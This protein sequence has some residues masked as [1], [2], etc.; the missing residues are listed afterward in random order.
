M[1]AVAESATVVLGEQE[2]R[3]IQGQISRG[4]RM[5]VTVGVQTAQWAAAC[6]PLRQMPEAQERAFPTLVHSPDLFRSPS[7]PKQR[8]RC[9]R[10]HLSWPQPG[11]I[12]FALP[13]PVEIAQEIAVGAQD[14]HRLLI[15]GLL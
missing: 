7:A 4:S 3:L 14:Q 2:C 10:G 11:A 12:S 13:S 15:Q 6:L 5:G 8:S 1:I 9:V